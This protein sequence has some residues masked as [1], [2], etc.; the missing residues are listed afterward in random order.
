MNSN[1]PMLERMS[2]SARNDGQESYVFSDVG[3]ERE[4]RVGSDM[5]PM[6]CN[7]PPAI[8]HRPSRLWQNL[9]ASR[10]APL[11]LQD[12]SQPIFRAVIIMA[13]YAARLSGDLPCFKED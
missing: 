6:D 3:L 13:D 7:Y 2:L 9:A 8:D 4:T 11:D 1:E 12:N 10:R 5:A